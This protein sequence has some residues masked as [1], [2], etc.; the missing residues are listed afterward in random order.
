M[1]AF[2]GSTGTSLGGRAAQSFADHRVVVGDHEA[3]LSL[4]C[5][6]AAR[7]LTRTLLT[8][9]RAVDVLAARVAEL[10]EDRADGDTATL[11]QALLGERALELRGLD[12]ARIDE[13]QSETRIRRGLIQN[14]LQHPH[15]VERAEWLDHVCG[16][17]DRPRERAALP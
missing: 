5:R 4:R 13:E 11:A 10:D 12:H 9:D 8:R 6:R 15:E 3:D 1:R 17:P 7:D 14:E 16:R 2:G